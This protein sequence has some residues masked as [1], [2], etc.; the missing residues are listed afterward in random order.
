[1][2]ALRPSQSTP[3][4]VQLDLG[5]QVADLGRMPAANSKLWAI[6]IH[7]AGHAVVAAYYGLPFT[8]V[9]VQARGGGWLQL[10]RKKLEPLLRGPFCVPRRAGQV[11]VM[12]YSGYAAELKV[13]P[14][15]P[16]S[17]AEPDEEQN[18]GWLWETTRCERWFDRTTRRFRPPTEAELERMVT[19]RA[20][21]LRRVA[22]RLVGRV[23]PAIELVAKALLERERLT[24]SEVAAIVG[25]LVAKV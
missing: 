23:F 16:R 2:D 22:H 11:I 13:S 25:A 24:G 10:N 6:A 1:M 7:E 15:A 21:R 5:L 20:H 4:M 14:S 18:A 12:G 9:R 8:S 3:L 17:S 19:L